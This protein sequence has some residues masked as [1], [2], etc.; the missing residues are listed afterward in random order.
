MPATERAVTLQEVVKVQLCSW[1]CCLNSAR[2]C[3]KVSAAADSFI[4]DK[5]SNAKPPVGTAV[6]ILPLYFSGIRPARLVNVA[7]EP[8]TFAVSHYSLLANETT[9]SRTA[10]QRDSYC[11]TL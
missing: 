4:V 2:L 6:L 9:L 3:S 11:Q 1:H 5:G 10:S 7:N 8:P